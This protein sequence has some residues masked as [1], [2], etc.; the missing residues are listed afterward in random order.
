MHGTWDL[1]LLTPVE[2]S[3]P[4]REGVKDALIE[5]IIS[6]RLPAGHHLV[7]VDL[8][9]RL[10]VSRSPV[11]EALQALHREGWVDFKPS[12]GAF[13]HDPTEEEADEVFAVRVIL[14]VHS[15]RLAAQNAKPDDLD[16]LGQICHQGRQALAIGDQASVVRLNAALHKHITEMAHNATL[17]DLT[18]SLDNKVRWYFTSIAMARGSASWDEHEALLD[19][20]ADNDADRAAA[21]MQVHT[22]RSQR[23]HHEFRKQRKRSK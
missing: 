9:Q 3:G 14:E 2:R 5:L 21:V 6:R 23:A 12:R 7:E 15:A 4:L 11:R 20:F 10:H 18:T 13:V 22:E 8:A 19:A 16:T 17:A 1:A